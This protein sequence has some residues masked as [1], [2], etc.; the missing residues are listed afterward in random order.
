[1]QAAS[2]TKKRAPDRESRAAAGM[3]AAM[4][5]ARKRDI[6]IIAAVAVAGLLLWAVLRGAFAKPGTYA[7]IYYQSKLVQTVALEAGA[8]ESF[9]IE[10]LPQ[11]VFHRYADGSIAFLESD[12]PD[13]V[14]IHA[15]RL[16]QVGQMAAC[17]PNEVYMKIVGAI[18][19][20]DAPDLVIG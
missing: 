3:E 9:S 20:P 4:K 11:V 6:L 19:D 15:G 18:A 13:K 8:E 2:R 7:E 16:R 14:C 10:G 12:C 1:M 17:L 5:F